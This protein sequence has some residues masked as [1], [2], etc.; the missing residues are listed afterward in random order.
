MTTDVDICNFALG[1]LG[2]EPID[3]LGTDT[4][5]ERTCARFYAQVRDVYLQEHNWS[6]TTKTVELTEID[7]LPDGYGRFV[8]GY[9]YPSDCLK[10][11]KIRDGE[12]SFAYPFIIKDYEA[13]GPVDAK[14]ILT[15][16]ADAYLEYTVAL[17]DPDLFTDIFIEGLYKKLAFQISWPLTQDL[18][19]QK[20]AFEQF[21]LADQMAKQ[22]DSSEQM[23]QRPPPTW[24][25]SRGSVPLDSKIESYTW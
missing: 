12:S 17:T 25:Q 1:S 3:A 24:E 13:A 5:S 23:P 15:D 2:L 22:Y 10:A 21:V 9:E 16:L 8:Y 7:P 18:R 4:Q 11:Q 19:I 14:I 20:Q 6:F